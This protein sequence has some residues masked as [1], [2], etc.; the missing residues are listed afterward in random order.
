MKIV[1]IGSIAA[2]VSVA[3]KLSA[4]ESSARIVVYEKGSFYSCGACGLPYYL[5]ESREELK[6]AITG[7]EDELAASGIEAHL[8]CEVRQIEPAAHRL[9]VCE[10]DS[11]RVFADTYD[12][13]VLA[14]GSSNI[15]PQV[16][17]CNRVGVQTFKTVDDLIF[18]QEYTRTPY[19]RD[20]VILG[21]SYAG[22]E[23]A[24]AFHKMGSNV[25]IIEKERKLLPSFDGEVSA[26]I[27]KELETEGVAFSLG[28]SVTAFPGQTFIEKVQT[29]RASYDC[30]LCIVAIGVRPN[31]ALAASAGIALDGSGAVIVNNQLETSVR[32]I[33]AV[34][35]C[36]ACSE[37]GQRT[38]SLRAAGIE[39]ART[40][41]TEEEAKRAGI[42]VKSAIA[43]GSD[44][45]GICPN[46]N[47]VTIK[48]VYEAATRRVVGAQAWGHKNA[49]ARV[50][51]IAVA[52]AAGMTVEQLGNVDFVYSSSAASI[53]DPIQIVCNAAK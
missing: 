51:A 9:T 41:M 20:I 13:L 47:R 29:N 32:D 23:I 28:E 40:G 38:S 44:R 33:Y 17:G 26:L 36:T 50:N 39:I 48:L 30:D 22:L 53:W 7:K 12:K 45:P 46:P 5:T 52:A 10:L 1:V 49:A 2:G 25:R 16:P 37:P 11:G 6:K 27:Q 4:A 43:S 3:A 34:G 21:G 8:R 35:D 19:V 14:T 31:T 15:I 42:R 24:K 18:L